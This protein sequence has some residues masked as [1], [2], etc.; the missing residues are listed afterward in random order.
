VLP[1]LPIFKFTNKEL[2]PQLPTP[3]PDPPSPILEPLELPEI[4]LELPPSPQPLP[5]PMPSQAVKLP[6][7]MHIEPPLH[8]KKRRY[9]KPQ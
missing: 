1:P 8:N 2:P 7:E 6:P 5:L 3:P 4:N 9:D